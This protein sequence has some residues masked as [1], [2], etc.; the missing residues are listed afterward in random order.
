MAR[1]E[2]LRDPSPV[3]SAVEVHLRVS[4]SAED[5]VEVVSCDCRCVLTKVG[6]LFE[7]RSTR[8][9]GSWTQQLIVECPG[10]VALAELRD[11]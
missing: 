6:T 1:H 11:T 5:L 7:A 10:T 3:R 4:K 8:A 9:N 2:R